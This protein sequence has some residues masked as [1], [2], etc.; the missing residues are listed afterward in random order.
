MAKQYSEKL[1]DP[2]WQKIRLQVFERDEWTCQSCGSKERNLQVHHLKYFSGKDPWEYELHFLITYC[3]QCH[4]TEHLI[5]DQIRGILHEL[6]DA[7]K[8]FIRP[9][10]QINHL[11]EHYEPFYPLLK[12][13]L[14]TCLI[15]CLKSKT[16]KKAA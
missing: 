10:A 2:R 12:E 4:E 1:K 9:L 3:D 8:I 6:I 7:D 5:G 16:P 14:N 15:E 11:I 13:F